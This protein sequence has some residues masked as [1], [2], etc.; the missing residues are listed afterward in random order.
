MTTS[1]E[2]LLASDFTPRSDLPQKQAMMLAQA[3]GAALVIAHVFDKH[4]AVEAEAGE[5]TDFRRSLPESLKHCEVITARGRAPHELAHL[6][7][8]RSSRL[9]VTGVARHNS[10]GD[11]I[12]GTMVDYLVRRAPVPVLVVKRDERLYQNIVVA[13][14]YSPPSLQALLMAA[15]MFP[16]A[17]FTLV[18]AF[19]IPFES[20]ISSDEALAEFR[21]MAEDDMEKFMSSEL[22]TQALRSRL[23]TVVAHGESGSIV[24][25]QV[26]VSDADLLVLASNGRS[27][28]FHAAIGSI[29]AALLERAKCDVLM[30]RAGKPK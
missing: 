12:L 26:I 4:T 19:S 14:D 30:V 23:R 25:L 1:N 7:E 6:A 3:M 22:I 8:A 10:L 20:W 29:S 18:H 28:L 5:V 17:S 11:E 27:A 16:H 21:K 9:I 2:I 24:S 13:T 15:E